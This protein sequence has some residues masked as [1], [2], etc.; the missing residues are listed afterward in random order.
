MKKL[1]IKKDKF[2]CDLWNVI[3][4]KRYK[5][6]KIVSDDF[7]G[8]VSLINLDNVSTPQ[9]WEVKGEKIIVCD[10]GMKWLRILPE[11]ENYTIMAIINEKDEI[12]IWYIDII[13][14]YGID[15]DGIVYVNDL[16]LDLIVN[17]KGNVKID[18]MDELEI[19]L[20][21]EVISLE[22]YNCALETSE[23]IKND[24]L[25]DINRFNEYC[26]KLLKKVM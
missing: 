10:N 9:I 11:G 15:E 6:E 8:Y 7:I 22:L 25:L 16:F 5:Q 21:Q 3:T 2:T 4:E 26:T 13:K 23:K 20:N 18:D 24:I 19:A 1:K 12:V 14:D 17:K